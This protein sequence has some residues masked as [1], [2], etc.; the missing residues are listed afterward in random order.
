MLSGMAAGKA[1]TD[2][3]SFEKSVAWAILPDATKCGVRQECQPTL[4]NCMC[5]F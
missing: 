1:A 5:M 3:L 2:V 4:E